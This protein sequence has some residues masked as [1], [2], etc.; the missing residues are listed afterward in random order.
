[1]RSRLWLTFE[2]V[3]VVCAAVASLFS[4][5][6]GQW[7]AKELGHIW[8]FVA[9]FGIMTA[10]FMSIKTPSANQ[11]KKRRKTRF[12]FSLS[13][14]F[15]AQRPSVPTRTTPSKSTTSGTARNTRRSST[16]ARTAPTTSTT[17]R[18]TT[19]ASPRSR[20]T[21]PLAQTLLRPPLLHMASR[22]TETEPIEPSSLSCVSVRGKSDPHPSFLLS[23]CA[24]RTPSTILFVNCDC[25]FCVCCFSSPLTSHTPRIFTSASLPTLP[26]Q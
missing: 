5:T 20:T 17:T 10:T 3:R 26:E 22:T 8:P 24:P 2:C 18:R 13:F 4:R 1:V 15:A 12:F 25:F 9:G 21:S 14:V 6:G 23:S 7:A 11:Q 16:T 19:R